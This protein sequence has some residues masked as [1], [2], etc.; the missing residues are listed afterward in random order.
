[1]LASSLATQL[2]QAEKSFQTS[3]ENSGKVWGDAFLKMVQANV[4]IE[5]V[6]ILSD[7]VTPAV[8]QN[9]NKNN[10]RGGSE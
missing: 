4:P 3:A 1:M 2:L 8:Q 7:L 10:D 5:L 6:R 9:I